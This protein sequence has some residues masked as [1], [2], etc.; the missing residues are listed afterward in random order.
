MIK[1]DAYYSM[2]RACL[3]FLYL[4]NLSASAQQND[5][6][7]TKLIKQYLQDPRITLN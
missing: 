4:T 6:K 1:M 3:V 5:E 2:M 7:Y